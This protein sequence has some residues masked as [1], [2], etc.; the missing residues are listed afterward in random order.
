MKVQIKSFDVDMEV[1]NNGV[2]FQVH[3]N[4]GKFKGDFYV[5][6]SG[7]IWCPGKTSREK[8]K[9]ITWDNFITWIE[10]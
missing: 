9:K 6:K 10:G 7:V 2:E 1:K 4:S 3:D 5:T 8:G